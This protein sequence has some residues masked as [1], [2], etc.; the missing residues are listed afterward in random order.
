M[1][2]VL[3]TNCADEGGDEGGFAFISLVLNVCLEEWWP[4]LRA[5]LSV[6]AWAK[7]L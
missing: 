2:W 3:I 5:V 1:P 4:M 6:Q 7:Y